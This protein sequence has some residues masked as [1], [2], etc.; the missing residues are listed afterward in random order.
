[1]IFYKQMNW[2]VSDL[3]IS[4]ASSRQKSFSWCLGRFSA[5]ARE[6]GYKIEATWSKTPIMQLW[7]HTIDKRV[8]QL[9]H[10]AQK[11]YLSTGQRAFSLLPIHSISTKISKCPA[12]WV[13]QDGVRIFFFLI[14][15]TSD[16]HEKGGG[17]SI[18]LSSNNFFLLLRNKIVFCYF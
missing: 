12:R 3:T 8:I 4:S 11:M 7:R 16:E 5:R 18:V 13:I 15:P 1:M 2:A 14:P 10:R 6:K 17:H 9:W